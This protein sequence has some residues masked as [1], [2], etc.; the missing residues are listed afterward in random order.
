MKDVIICGYGVI[1]KRV[2]HALRRHGIS[3]IALDKKEDVF[4]KDTVH[5]HGDATSEDILRKAGIDEAKTIVASTDDDIT[6]AFIT[7]LAKQLN[8]DITILASVEDIENIDKLDKAGADYVFSMAKVG[9]FIARSAIEPFVAE[10][11][12]MVNL[13]EGVEIM[14]IGI[15]D[16]SILTNKTI[17]KAKI[18]RN[19]GANIIAI[20]RGK[21]TIYSPSEEEV[22]VPNDILLAIGNAE[23]IRA[24]FNLAEPEKSIEIN[25]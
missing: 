4:D 17:K 24:L 9:R 25:Q 10:F 22:I 23:Q 11:L 1:G 18:L 13:M 14:P 19:T 8:K 20:R 21:D 12:D 7:L 15:S 3:Y 6:N 16:N 5:I 2:A